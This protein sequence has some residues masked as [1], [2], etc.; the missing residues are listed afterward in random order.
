M[1]KH[2]PLSEH[3]ALEIALAFGGDALES[4]APV[5]GC[6]CTRCQ[7]LTV[8]G[9]EADVLEAELAVLVLSRLPVNER[10]DEAHRWGEERER[11]GRS[12]T[13]P[14]PGVLAMI[15][16][17]EPG[18]VRWSSG[19]AKPSV[20]D[21]RATWQ[22]EW[23]RR[24]A[25]ARHLSVLDVARIL[26]CGEPVRR[27]KELVV[28]CPLHEDTDPSCRIDVEGGL[29]YCDPCAEGGDALALYMRVRQL[30]FVDA[31]RELVA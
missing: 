5:P 30:E 1:P 21:R 16:A 3:L 27:G 26:G 22:R 15:A 2:P 4:G 23:E 20:D 9:D 7:V 25:A 17:R 24:V 8:G 14:T 6:S 19:D 10:V 13:L 18:A 31:V 11:C 12:V 28:C 29:W